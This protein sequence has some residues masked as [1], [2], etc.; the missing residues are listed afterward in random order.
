MSYDAS[1][2]GRYDAICA[3]A[4]SLSNIGESH[5]SAKDDLAEAKQEHPKAK[6]AREKNDANIKEQTNRIELVKSH[7]K[8]AVTRTLGDRGI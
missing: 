7:C 2:F 6:G 1:F 5:A 4:H 3:E 8:S